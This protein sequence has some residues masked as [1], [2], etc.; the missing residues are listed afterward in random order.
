MGVSRWLQLMTARLP[1]APQLWKKNTAGGDNTASGFWALASSTG[2]RDT[3]VGSYALEEETT[4]SNNTAVGSAAGNPSPFQLT[5]DSNK[6]FLSALA[7]LFCWN[8]CMGRVLRPECRKS[9]TRLFPESVR[10]SFLAIPT[11]LGMW[12]CAIS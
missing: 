4:G 5:T 11:P 9:A 10:L 2:N 1:P 6:S 8:G 3:A 12:Y 7:S